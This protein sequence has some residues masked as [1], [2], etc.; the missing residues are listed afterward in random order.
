MTNAQW[1]S[2]STDANSGIPL[3][4]ELSDINFKIGTITMNYKVNGHKSRNKIRINNFN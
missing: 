4:L 3:M 2:Q 1:K